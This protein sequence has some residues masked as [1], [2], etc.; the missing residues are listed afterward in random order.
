[1]VVGPGEL[2]CA[3]HLTKL[4]QLVEK[5]GGN[6]TVHDDGLA[7]VIWEDAAR[8]AT[9]AIELREAL[10]MV[11]IALATGNGETAWTPAFLP[12]VERAT[13][14]LASAGSGKICLDESTAKLVEP[15]FDLKVTDDGTPTILVGPKSSEATA[16]TGRVLGNYKI[17]RLLGTG[18]MGVVYL[19]EH[20]TLGRKAVIKF[21]QE[22]HASDTNYIQRFLTEA[23]TAASIRHP[24]IVDVFDYGKDD[25]GR[26]YIVM[27]LLEGE[28]LRTRLHR[29]KSLS[30][31]LALALGAQIASGLDAAHTGGV[32][33][34]DLKPDNVFL[35]PDRELAHRVRAKV[36]DFG[37]SRKPGISLARPFTCR[38][39]K[40]ARK[41]RSITE[42]TSIPLVAF[43][44]RWF[45]AVLLFSTKLSAT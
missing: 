5:G 27:E 11:G 38:R 42:P 28:S 39:S 12:V 13:A 29:E 6:L 20:V 7:C 45:A 25:E 26:G 40:V 9:V 32:I 31:E 36:L 18:G 21:V 19:A 15:Q 37:P 8:G 33:H 43:C 44:S 24:G 4:R 16:L 22:R 17:V 34:R 1:M 2:I 23:T 30:P 14:I 10:P 3:D 35:V 41:P